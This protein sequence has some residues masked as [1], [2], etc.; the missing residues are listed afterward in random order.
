MRITIFGATGTLGRVIVQ[1][2]LAKGHDVT[3]FSRSDGA[4][5]HNMAHLNIV[6]GDVLD[7]AAV[8][9]A[10]ADADAVIC[11][12]GAGRNGKLRA[13]GTA[14]ILAGMTAQGVK[15]I[16]CLSSLGVGDSA[17][18]L[19]FFWKYIMFGLLLRPAFADHVAQEKLLRASNSDWTIV[20]P[21]AF[22]DGPLTGDFH[23]GFAAPT[24]LKLALKISR[25]DVAHFM[26]GQLGS[27]HY[28]RK[29]PSLSS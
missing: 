21:A 29:S 24:R 1:Q 15:R 13:N 8:S 22:T 3:A 23:H 26:L 12:L 25:A 10:I 17:K 16:I 4:L 14:N 18:N 20:R 7:G 2:A 9:A 11:A 5:D 28:L 19:N 6:K 27:D